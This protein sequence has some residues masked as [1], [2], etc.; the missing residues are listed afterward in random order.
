MGADRFATFHTADFTY[1]TVGDTPLD[2]TILIP[3]GV[4]TGKCPLLVHFH[5]GGLIVGDKMFAD[6]FAFWYV[7][8][9]S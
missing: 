4:K 7:L 8:L 9:P 3:K 5:G 6:W 1:K 2:L